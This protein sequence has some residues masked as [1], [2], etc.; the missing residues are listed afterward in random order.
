MANHVGD[1]CQAM[2]H[3]AWQRPMHVGHMACHVSTC[4][5]N[6]ECYKYG[7][8]AIRRRREQQEG[9]LRK[10][11]R[12]GKERKA[13]DENVMP[14]NPRVPLTTSQPAKFLWI[15]SNPIPHYCVPFIGIHIF[16][17]IG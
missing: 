8:G 14:Q 3:N 13:I 11:K 4:M 7:V 5:A 6:G 12:R 15:S 9:K 1:T 10:K 17:K 16:T 2:C